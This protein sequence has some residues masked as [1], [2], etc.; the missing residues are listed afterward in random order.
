M[1]NACNSIGFENAQCLIRLDPANTEA[2]ISTDI[3]CSLCFLLTSSLGNEAAE[4]SVAPTAFAHSFAYVALCAMH[5]MA[6]LLTL[7][8]PLMYF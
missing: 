7:P 2:A 1:A 6:E 8:S 3:T 4:W 5:V